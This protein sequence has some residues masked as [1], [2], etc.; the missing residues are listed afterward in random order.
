MNVNDAAYQ[1][2]HEYP[3]GAKAL[4]SRMDRIDRDGKVVEF[5]P[6]VLSSKVNPN[7]AT[8]H[9]T[10]AEASTIMGLTGDHRILHALAAQHGYI[11][12]ATERPTTGS[13]ICSLLAAGEAKG[14]L[15]G[16]V[17]EAVQDGS[18]S[19]NEAAAITRACAL[20][21]D[22]IAKVA[23]HANAQAAGQVA[24]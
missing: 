21:M 18:I 1:T 10:L 9:L 4:A 23:Q 15:Q 24:A 14:D 3:G 20:V 17:R 8:H 7:T 5:S 22:A 16:L 6:V 12:Q 19:T 11:L 13:I 2:V